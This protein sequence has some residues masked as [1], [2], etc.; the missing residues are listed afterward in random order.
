MRATV[1]ERGGV[2]T[3]RDLDAEQ[4]ARVAALL[5]ERRY[6]RARTV[7]AGLRAREEA[8]E[9]EMAVLERRL[10]E[11]CEASARALLA[12]VD[13][14]VERGKVLIAVQMLYSDEI[15]DYRDTEMWRPLLER[16]E[17]IEDLI[18][19]RGGQRPFPRRRHLPRGARGD[20]DGR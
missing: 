12:R 18:D 4:I 6:A 16:A 8:A 13:Q 15:A 20:G 11:E 9:Y 10:R 19:A 7:M 14:Q 3:V 5:D 1:A 2:D 17:E